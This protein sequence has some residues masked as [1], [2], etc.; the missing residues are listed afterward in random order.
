[1]IDTLGLYGA[2]TENFCLTLT[3][4][5]L[6]TLSPVQ[7]LTFGQPINWLGLVVGLMVTILAFMLVRDIRIA[8]PRI[9]TS[10]ATFL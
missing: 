5:I 7:G 4:A 2:Y 8:G 6:S 1:M 10:I 3:Y 9:S